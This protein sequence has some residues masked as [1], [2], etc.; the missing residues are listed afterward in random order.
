MFDFF[1][2]SSRV[3]CLP[4]E[5]DADRQRVEFSQMTDDSTPCI[6]LQGGTSSLKTFNLTPIIFT[7][8]IIFFVFPSCEFKPPDLS[9]QERKIADSL[10]RE[11]MK[12]YREEMDS[13]CQ[14]LQDSLIPI[15]KDS[16]LKM[17]ESEIQKQLERVRNS[18]E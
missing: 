2:N 13:V 4:L 9:I 3:T 18:V 1:Y 11:K 5:G 16:I 6:P 8:S 14:Q 10:Y 15:Y 17:R 12:T 7:F